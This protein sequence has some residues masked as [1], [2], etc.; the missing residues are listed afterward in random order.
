MRAFTEGFHDVIEQGIMSVFDPEE[1]ELLLGGTPNISIDDW[2]ANTT[3]SGLFNEKHPVIQWFWE[4]LDKLTQDQLRKLLIFC[5]GM[6][7][8]PLDGFK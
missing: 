1:L 4:I 2:R 5:T 8:V 6:P 3:F 7:R